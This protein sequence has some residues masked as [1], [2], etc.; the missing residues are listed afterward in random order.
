MGRNED[1][2]AADPGG[3][4][5]LLRIRGLEVRFGSFCAL[6]PLDLDVRDG[7]FLT[8]L[9][10]SGS[11][12]TTLLRA[13]AGFLRPDSGA[14]EFNG[15][16]I[17]GVPTNR[18]PFNTVFQ[19]YAL[20]PH[21]NV[22]DNVGFGLRMRG[23]RGGDL[24][25]RVDEALRVVGLEDLGGRYPSQLSGGQQQRTALARAMICEPKLILLDE[26]LAALDATLRRNMQDFLKSVQRKSG[27]TFLFVTHD[28]SEAITMSD[29]IC[30]MREGQIEQIGTPRDLYYRP[31][32]R[33]VA[34]FFGASNILG[35]C[36]VRESSGGT[37]TVATALG[38][39]EVEG[40]APESPGGLSLAVRP[41]AFVPGDG[42]RA[43]SLAVEVAAVTFNGSET[44]T[45]LRHRETGTTLTMKARSDPSA[46]PHEV[47]SAV[48][49]GFEP[50]ECAIVAD[51]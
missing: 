17:S 1:P 6:R 24:G 10:P 33:F 3:D 31:N 50:S 12:K 32:S 29:R 38:E 35:P 51:G 4:G 36:T 9:G 48:T 27:I 47:G 49:V 43:N 18:R 16:E 2:G 34:A 25:G 30:V 39:F 26:P 19:D 13:I 44:V 41:E 46:R 37:T 11:G 22:R 45:V 20:F 21:M 15:E 23:V 40:P 7:E 5:P 14:M 42:G 8:I 28:Q